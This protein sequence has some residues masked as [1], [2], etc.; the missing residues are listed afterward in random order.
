MARPPG[1]SAPKKNKF[2]GRAPATKLP[3]HHLL[4][5]Q[6]PSNGGGLLNGVGAGLDIA[7]ISRARDHGKWRFCRGEQIRVAGLKGLRCNIRQRSTSI[8]QNH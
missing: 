7:K 5:L 1:I 4:T 2:T 8:G 3:V 6:A